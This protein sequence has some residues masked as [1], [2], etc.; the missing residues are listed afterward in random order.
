MTAG[1]SGKPLAE[2][3]GIKSGSRAAVIH[4]PAGYDL[5]TLPPGVTIS[6]E[7]AGTL[8]FI[9]FF[10]RERIELEREFPVLQK[11][12][13][14]NGALWISWPKATAP[15][16]IRLSADLNENFIRDIGLKNGLVDVKVIAV[17]AVWS[18]L[19]FVYRLKDRQPGV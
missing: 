4:A 1:Y 14:Q 11:S 17:D 8:D 18:G 6:E 2:K 9:Q 7:I 16:S 13:A 3:L 19:K 15:K 12:L 5:G 10:T